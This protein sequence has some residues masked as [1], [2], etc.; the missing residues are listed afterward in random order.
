LLYFLY[1]NF[2]FIGDSFTYGIRNTIKSK[3][4]NVY[5]QAQGGRDLLIG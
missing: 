2:L 1:D 5:I 3:N 4:N